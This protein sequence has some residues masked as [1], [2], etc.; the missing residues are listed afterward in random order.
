MKY[1]FLHRFYLC[2]LFLFFTLS[3]QAA[4]VYTL[5]PMHTYVAWR[6]NHFGFSNPSGKWMAN[7]T[8]TLDDKKPQDSKV[9]VTIQTA[10]VVTG[11]A[12]LDEHL[13]GKLFFDVAEFPTATFVS[14]KI[15]I[16][17]KNKALVH[18]I[19]TLR[20]ISKPVTLDVTLNKM[21]VNPITNKNAVG[22]SATAQIKRSDFGMTT[23]LPGLSDD[24]KLNIE[25]EGFKNS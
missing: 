11:I 4:D 5:D 19:L 20:G 2:I 21:G 12:Q 22:F 3:A 24:V 23:L 25:A 15:D 9:S 6:I 13:Q 1:H 8:L 7:G 18:G 14:N 16:K 17:G 10:N